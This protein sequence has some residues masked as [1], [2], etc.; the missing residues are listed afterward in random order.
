MK[1]F[2]FYLPSGAITNTLTAPGEAIAELQGGSFIECDS[3]VSDTTHYVSGGKV[4]QKAAFTYQLKQQGLTLTLEGLPVNTSVTVGDFSVLTDNKP[5]V[6][7]FDIPG[8]RV[9]YIKDSIPHLDETLE[10]TVGHP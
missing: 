8:K 5:T 1:T 7:E 10:V 6:I 3:D 4:K 9:I 2:A